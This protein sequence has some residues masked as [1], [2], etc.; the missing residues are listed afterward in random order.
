MNFVCGKHPYDYV[1]KHIPTIPGKLRPAIDSNTS[2]RLNDL[3]RE[4]YEYRQ[5]EANF[6]KIKEE[7]RSQIA[8]MI[9]DIIAKFREDVILIYEKIHP[10]GFVPNIYIDPDFDEQTLKLRIDFCEPGRTVPPAGYLSES[11][12]NTL[13]L[14]LFL[15]SVRFFNRQF[16]FIFLDDIVSSYDA[17]HR[18]RIVDVIAESLEDF[19]VFLTTHDHMFY[20]MLRDRLSDKGWLFNRITRWDL[21]HGPQREGDSLLDS[22]IEQ[23]IQS[24]NTKAAGNAVR[25]YMEEWLDKACEK[26]QVHT[27]H[28]RGHK[29]YKRTLFDFWN[30][31]L[32]RIQ[33]FNGDFFN[34][35][36]ETQ[37]CY[38]RI[39]SSTLINYY[40]HAQ[41]DP[42]EWPC[43]G[44]VTYVWTEFKNFQNLFYCF[45]CKKLLEYSPDRN[46]LFCTCG[47]QIF[48]DS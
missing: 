45:S 34:K 32:G 37:D 39:K 48:P 40:S 25:Q 17:D 23:L 26:F 2:K 19:Q 42:Y 38:D 13:G 10:L 20:T 47:Q 7:I 31:F 1:G 24:G 21:D 30:P 11:Y 43:L 18:A 6:N 12:I 41:S 14:A 35:Y 16:P 9:N 46:R 27:L 8:I 22:E 33:S 5:I 28:K 36:V 4:H 44:D 29:D 15:S 3:D